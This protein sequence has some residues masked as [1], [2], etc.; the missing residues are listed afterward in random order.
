MKKKLLVVFSFLVFFMLFSEILSVRKT[1]V[2]NEW[3][4]NYVKDIA[5]TCSPSELQ[6]PQSYIMDNVFMACREN[7]VSQIEFI[8]NTPRTRLPVTATINFY[9]K[10]FSIVVTVSD[11]IIAY[12]STSGYWSEKVE[13]LETVSEE[14]M[15]ELKGTEHYREW[16]LAIK[17]EI[18]TL[19]IL[20]N[21]FPDAQIYWDTPEELKEEILASSL[22]ELSFFKRIFLNPW[23]SYTKEKAEILYNTYEEHMVEEDL[24]R[25]SADLFLLYGIHMNQEQI[26]EDFDYSFGLDVDFRFLIV[27]EFVTISLLSLA[28]TGI[29]VLVLFYRKSPAVV[30]GIAAG[31]LA[32]F[33]SQSYLAAFLFAGAGF[34]AVFLTCRIYRNP[35][36]YKESTLVSLKTGIVLFLAYYVFNAVFGLFEVIQR[37]SQG[38]D[39][40][41]GNEVLLIVF[42]LGSLLY[43][44]AATTLGGIVANA[45]FSRTVH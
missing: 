23:D 37:E 22:Q 31:I 33:V 24:V 11:N 21:Q 43:T 44:C 25:A 30:A 32:V 29:V 28:A 12:A 38:L 39:S 5:P 2:L 4:D 40:L 7:L 10:L 6:D 19:E 15:A 35:L 34:A 20:K 16:R 14:T 18:A 17:D 8:R 36:N 41:L 42:S 45:V 26:K 1:H 27:F 13:E 3:A 9:G